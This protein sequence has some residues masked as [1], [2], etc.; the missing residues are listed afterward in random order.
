MTTDEAK[1]LVAGQL[2]YEVQH[3]CTLVWVVAK[4]A[5]A[6]PETRGY[7]GFNITLHGGRTGVYYMGTHTCKNFSVVPSFRK[8]DG[9]G[10]RALGDRVG[11]PIGSH[12]DSGSV[13]RDG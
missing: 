7:R 10:G 13:A 8:E 12:P 2:V 5:L 11:I 1:A 4:V 9:D 3:D 6:P